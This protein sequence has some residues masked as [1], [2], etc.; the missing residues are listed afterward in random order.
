MAQSP[1]A[2]A[3]AVT[4]LGLL[5][6]FQLISQFGLPNVGFFH[7]QRSTEDVTTAPNQTPLIPA[8][9]QPAIPEDEPTYLLGAG[10]A[11]ITGYTLPGK[12][13]VGRLTVEP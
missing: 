1:I 2:A 12:H 11:D 5:I 3:L 9:P 4:F 7:F 10:R 13:R 6:T 8:G